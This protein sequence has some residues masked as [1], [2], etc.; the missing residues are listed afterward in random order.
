MHFCIQY[1]KIHL[2]TSCL[3]NELN[4]FVST[5]VHVHS[6]YYKKQT[7]EKSFPN[8]TGCQSSMDLFYKM[9]ACLRSIAC[10]SVVT[11]VTIMIIF[12]SSSFTSCVH[13]HCCTYWSGY[14]CPNS[15][16]S[17]SGSLCLPK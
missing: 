9:F 5:I 4:S 13:L 17:D 12:I 7:H 16:F 2:Q 15:C 11:M 8:I 14:Y 10:V 6:N 1:Y 3:L